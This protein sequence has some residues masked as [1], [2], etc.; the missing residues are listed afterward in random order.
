MCASVHTLECNVP[1]QQIYQI[2]SL[3]RC[4]GTKHSHFPCFNMPCIYLMRLFTDR[5]HACTTMFTSDLVFNDASTT[6]VRFRVYIL[7][8]TGQY[9]RRTCRDCNVQKTLTGPRDFAD[10]TTPQ[11]SRNHAVSFHIQYI[12]FHTMPTSMDLK[13]LQSFRS[14]TR[15]HTKIC[16]CCH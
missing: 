13:Q 11:V 5:P 9:P 12:R 6:N 3:A 16:P 14:S 4:K 2:R 1:P 7:F 8:S 10:K 15:Q